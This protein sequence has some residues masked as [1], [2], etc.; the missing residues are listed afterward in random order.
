MNF[1][2]DKQLKAPL[3]SGLTSKQ[4]SLVIIVMV[5]LSYISL[6]S[7]IASKLL[8][9]PFLSALYFSVASLESIGNIY[10]LD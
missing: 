1:P 2:R 9:I 8:D 5:L 7:F 6:G 3:G 4:R 10:S